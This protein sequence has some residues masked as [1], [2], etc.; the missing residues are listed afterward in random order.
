MHYVSAHVSI[1][2]CRRGCGIALQ[3][4]L[5]KSHT[6]LKDSSQIIAIQVKLSSRSA[7]RS[8]L[9]IN[10]Q[11]ASGGA[12]SKIWVLTG[13]TDTIRACMGTSTPSGNY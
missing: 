4:I 3:V 10:M 2:I 6:S 13:C 7:H 11:A 5:D 9:Y 1:S 12:F 8:W